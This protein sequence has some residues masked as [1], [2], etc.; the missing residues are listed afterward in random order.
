MREKKGPDLK[1]QTELWAV[2]SKRSIKFDTRTNN[3]Q[4]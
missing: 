1:A 4:W 3:E 2:T